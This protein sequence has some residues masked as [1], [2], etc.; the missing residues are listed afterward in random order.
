MQDLIRD[1]LG[2][3]ALPAPRL[4]A[5]IYE[6]ID[7]DAYIIEVP[8]PGLDPSQIL[9]DATPE[10]LTVRTMPDR[11]DSADNRRYL[12]REHDRGP[13][14]RVFEFP[15]EIDP[16]HVRASLEAGMLKLH[17]PK[18]LVNPRRVIKLQ[19]DAA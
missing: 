3:R 17:V 15:V 13:A 2:S 11:D 1:F 5:D 7:G 14:T 8:V 4:T 10:G 18:A 12:Q 9:V 19:Q 6:S 16:D